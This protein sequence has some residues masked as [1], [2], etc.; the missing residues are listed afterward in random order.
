MLSIHV[1]LMCVYYYYID[2]GGRSFVGSFSFRRHKGASIFSL[3]CD[4][5]VGMIGQF[6]DGETVT[7]DDGMQNPF[8]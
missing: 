4:V 8:G 2:A 6:G 7:K 1:S 3:V 5:V